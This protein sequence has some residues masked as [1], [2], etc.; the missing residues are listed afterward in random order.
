MRAL[1]LLL[2]WPVALTIAVPL[3]YPQSPSTEAKEQVPENVDPNDG[4][5]EAMA[6]A[7]GVLGSGMLGNP[8]NWRLPRFRKPLAGNRMFSGLRQRV[9]P[10]M[11]ALKTFK[12]QGTIALRNKLGLPTEP[13]PSSP[14]GQKT[15]PS[16]KSP[17]ESLDQKKIKTTIESIESMSD[18]QFLSS[19]SDEDARVAEICVHNAIGELQHVPV[20]WA[21]L[22]AAKPELSWEAA[23]KEWVT[24]YVKKCEAACIE[25]QRE[26]T[27]KY[28][29]MKLRNLKAEAKREAEKKEDERIDILEQKSREK[30]KELEKLAG[31][32]SR[33]FTG[34][35]QT[36]PGAPGGVPPVRAPLRVPM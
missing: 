29:K 32:V 18:G 33:Y 8:R 7:G 5:G 13:E 25:R 23:R 15:S 28:L 4:A 24:S 1:H 26:R 20:P 11:D 17:P 12:Q 6:F 16:P 10:Q 14:A 35:A 21:A 36:V 30:A 34:P 19:L 3:A 22:K 27:V 31:T 2:L 9:S